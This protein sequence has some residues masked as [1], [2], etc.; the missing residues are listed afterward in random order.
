[1]SAKR[2]LVSGGSGFIPSHLVRRLLGDGYE[3]AVTLRYGNPIKN[4][5]L[6]DIWDD[7]LPLEADLRNRG[8]LGLALTEFKPEIV[9][10]LAAYNHV[11]QSF[12]QV[13]EC[14]DVNA[15]GTANILDCSEIAGVR[16][17]VYMS[18]SEVYGEQLSVP[19]IE[20]MNP[21][22]I[23]P[24]A[25]TKYSG[26]MYCRM[27]QLMENGID[28]AILRPFNVYGP[29]QSSK[30]VIP[31]LI[32]KCLRGETVR[33]TKGK[34]TR[35]F[36]YVDDVVEGLILAGESNER[37]EG[38]INIAAAEEVSICDLVHKV[39]QLTNTS[40]SI[41][42]G[43]LPYRPT[44][45]WRMYADNARAKGILNWLPKISLSEGLSKTI[46]WFRR[47]LCL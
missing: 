13:E 29:Y 47:Y 44:E 36:N 23:S 35:E 28:I 32:I 6:K 41:E 8:A 43:A 4:E 30:A 34:Q 37:I 16:K 38:P 10:H 26:E 25:I 2:V 40:S 5:R 20:S 42:V 7:I 31:E 11:G 27:K 17:F 24:Y 1:M 21:Q 9:F 33:T 18:T 46:D 14:F 15:K 3:V 19:F 22:P 45:I 39:A 12:V